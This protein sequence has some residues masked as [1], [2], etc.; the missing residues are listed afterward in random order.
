M[1]TE[2]GAA[3][4]EDSTP[5]APAPEG[6]ELRQLVKQELEL[7][8]ERKVAKTKF[9]RK[10]NRIKEGISNDDPYDTLN[11][12]YSDLE[13]AFSSLELA[14]ENYVIFLDSFGTCIC[15]L[16]ICKITYILSPAGYN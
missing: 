8:Q 2:E 12:I 4:F 5:E 15:V 3:A 13:K 11:M 7:R 1:N 14:G 10:F 9:T 16:L 6:E